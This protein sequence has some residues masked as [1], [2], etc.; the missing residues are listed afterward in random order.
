ME[1]NLQALALQLS[2][3]RVSSRIYPDSLGR[4]WSA[5][6]CHQSGEVLVSGEP[7]YEFADWGGADHVG[8]GSHGSLHRGDSLGVL[9]GCGLE[10]PQREQW[11][12]ADV[13]PLVLDYFQVPS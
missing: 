10:L 12:L 13:V 1:G 8:G 4:L 6:A 7:G 3:G 2:D 11:S 5:L 9:L